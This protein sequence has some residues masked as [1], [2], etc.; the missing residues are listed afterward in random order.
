MLLLDE[1]LSSLDA[2]LR[3]QMR[4]ELRR[5]QREYGM[6][7]V[8]V[9]HDQAEGL[10]LADTVAVMSGGKLLQVGQPRQIYEA[11]A[12]L[13]VAD[14]IGSINLLAARPTGR[15]NT[16]GEH[17]MATDWGE[18]ATTNPCGAK[19]GPVV[20][21]IRPENVRIRDANYGSNVFR[22]TA[23]TVMYYGSHQQIFIDIGG[24]V[25]M[26]VT[27]PNTRIKNGEM[28]L[29][30]VDATDVAVVSTDE[31]ANKSLG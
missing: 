29:F 19:N 18:V 13:E 26:A 6:T 12:N 17:L 3:E 23:Q 7:T 4:V 11:P 10:S 9:T 20:L 31:R 14:F 22:G 28:L 16:A 25:M 8:F 15:S 21:G 27:P 2:R 5:L 30:S 24:K 1:P